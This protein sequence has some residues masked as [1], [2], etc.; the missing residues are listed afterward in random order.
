MS[1]LVLLASMVMMIVLPMRAARLSNPHQGLRRAVTSTLLFNV[2]WAA[3]VLGAFFVLLRN[4]SLL[5]PEA[6]NR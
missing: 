6:V 3:L 1:K 2:V 4:P 5:F